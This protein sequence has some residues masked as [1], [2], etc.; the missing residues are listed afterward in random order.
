MAEKPGSI[1]AHGHCGHYYEKLDNL[2][3]KANAHDD[4]SHISQRVDDYCELKVA[5]PPSPPDW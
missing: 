1:R 3:R 2:Q 5:P 4:L